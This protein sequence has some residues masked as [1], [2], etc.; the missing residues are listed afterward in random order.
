MTERVVPGLPEGG[1]NELAQCRD[2]LMLFN[3][4]DQ[5][6]GASL[7]KYGEWSASEMALLRQVLSPGA[8]VVEGGA[9]VG[10]H[11]IALSR[12]AGRTGQ[13]HAFEPQRLVF[14]TLCA[15][16]ALNSCVNVF[17][18]YA[19]L[20]AQPGEIAV[21]W[22]PPDTPTNF[23]GLS[24][25]LEVGGERVPLR[26]IDDLALP[27]CHLIKLDV[28]GMELDALLGASETVH[29]YRPHLYVEN[30]REELAAAL[31][32]LLQSWNYDL[33]WHVLPLFSADNFAGDRENIF[34]RICSFNMIC[35]AA[36]RRVSV[37]GTR[38][39]EQ[40]RKLPR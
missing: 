29:R 25:R 12:L 33:Y 4:Y 35:C 27:A 24:L 3:R 5:F 14:Q 34:G 39:I 8:V 1:F 6:I 20:G 40:R 21:P 10:A 31:I 36:E 30:D 28:E 22:L 11:T 16:V 26:R 32:E 2:G 9:N 37:P 19:A 7:R 13:I 23:G 38:K 15:N 18:H 17:A